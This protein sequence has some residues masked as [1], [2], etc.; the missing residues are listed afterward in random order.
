MYFLPMHIYDGSFPCM[1]KYLTI[2]ILDDI[3][4]K[5]IHLILYKRLPKVKVAARSCPSCKKALGWAEKTG[6]APPKREFLTNWCRREKAKRKKV[7]VTQVWNW[8]CSSKEKSLSKILQGVELIFP[9]S[10]LWHCPHGQK[11]KFRQRQKCLFCKEVTFKP[12]V[13]S[14]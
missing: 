10:L 2:I 4:N 5:Y 3:S 13:L 8:W 12:H 11:E 14:S 9:L 6:A 7:K 1:C